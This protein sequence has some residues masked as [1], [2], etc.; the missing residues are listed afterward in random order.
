[1]VLLPL[2]DLDELVDL[3]GL[4]DFDEREERVSF[5]APLFWDELFLVLLLLDLPLLLFSESFAERAD[6]S[7]RVELFLPV[8]LFLFVEEDLLPVSPCLVFLCELRSRTRFSSSE[9]AFFLPVPV[10]FVDLVDLLKFLRIL[11]D[12]R[13]SLP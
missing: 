1:M 4:L 10:W 5:L 9:P 7:E 13:L 11:S 12:I 6:V 2:L 8:E 3:D